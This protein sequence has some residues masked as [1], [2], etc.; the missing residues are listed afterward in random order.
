MI[1]ENLF[2]KMRHCMDIS[3]NAKYNVLMKNVTDKNQFSHL[4]SQV[5]PEDGVS[6]QEA[7]VNDTIQPHCN[8][9][10]DLSHDT[11]DLPRLRSNIL[12]KN[13]CP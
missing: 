10:F 11:N 8:F 3:L 2:E 5:Y 1:T 12:R 7:Y 4:A 13:I 6:L 9:F